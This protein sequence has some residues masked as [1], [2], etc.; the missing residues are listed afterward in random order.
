M[1]QN[2]SLGDRLNNFKNKESEQHQPVQKIGFISPI[3]SIINS[4]ITLVVIFIK[5]FAFGYGLMTII[6]ASWPFIGYICVG[7]GINFL[8]EF[9]LDLIALFVTKQ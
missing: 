6:G 5:S 2:D 4:L 8:F 3:L 9:I 7:L 1:I